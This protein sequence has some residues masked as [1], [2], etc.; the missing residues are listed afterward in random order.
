MEDSGVR[1]RVVES[2]DEHM[3]S[4]VFANSKVR[5]NIVLSEHED[6]VDGEIA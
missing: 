1:E 6:A 3:G 5:V 2:G 4:Y